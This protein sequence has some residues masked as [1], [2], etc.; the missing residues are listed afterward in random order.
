MPRDT[1]L[2]YIRQI[3][4]ERDE[5]IRE[6]DEARAVAQALVAYQDDINAA[7]NADTLG[8]SRPDF[9]AF[10][11]RFAGIIYAARAIT[12]KDATP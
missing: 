7:I 4:R 3:E 10:A 6:R 11:A 1:A 2:D 8:T 5:A 12:T 9:D